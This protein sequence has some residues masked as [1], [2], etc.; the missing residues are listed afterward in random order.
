MDDAVPPSHPGVLTP[1]LETGMKTVPFA[2]L[3]L[4]AALALTACERQPVKPIPPTPVAS[5]P[6]LPPPPVRPL[7]FDQVDGDAKLVLRIAP[8]IA[9]HP[10]LL[11]ALY[12]QE[13]AAL[14]AFGAQARTQHRADNGSYP[15]RPHERQVHWTLSAEAPPLVGLRG[16]W[17]ED[18]GGAHPNHGVRTLIW[19]EAAQIT[20]PS[21]ALL[22]PGADLSRLNQAICD[23][24]KAAK[25]LRG[26]VPLEGLW[27]CPSWSETP[28]ALTPSTAPGKIG[29]L[30]A[31]IGSYVVGPYAEGQYEVVAPLSAFQADLNPTYAA[32][33]AGAP[34]SLG[35]PDGTATVRMDYVK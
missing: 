9:R 35:N 5:T 29:G 26:G 4:A 23:A 25:R 19:D 14:E 13:V 3:A 17:V 18:Q 32:A 21:S 22:R 7:A 30:T 24:V 2:T 31:L 16:E 11:Q 12:D 34:K 20:V 27:A 8:D 1:I 15:W 6:A 10:D 33:F 28:L